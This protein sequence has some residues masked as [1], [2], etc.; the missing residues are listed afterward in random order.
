MVDTS[1][2]HAI[3][4]GD[5]QVDDD[6]NCRLEITP[7]DVLDLANDIQKNGLIQPVTVTPLKDHEKYKYRLICG[8]RRFKAHKGLEM[9]TIDCIVKENLDETAARLYNIKENLMR[10]QL[11]ILEEAKAIERLEHLGLT[12]M[13]AARE[14]QQSRGWVQVRFM[15][16]RLPREI[17]S[18]CAAGILTQEDIRELYTKDSDAQIN[19]VKTIKE[20]KLKGQSVA[21]AKAKQKRNP[22]AKRIRK[23]PEIFDMMEHLSKN[24]GFGIWTRAMAWIAGEITDRELFES[25]KE[26][27]DE[28]N[29]EY[30][31]PESGD[32]Y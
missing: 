23:R 1:K 32:Q 30:T 26:Y 10:K 20:A 21:R 16:L 24:I 12:E 15:L 18:E 25:M 9:P 29:I 13:D 4:L 5:I 28:N 31:I 2:V 19:Y 7:L 22:N 17:Q 8:F 6:F 3:P 27:C 14:L 11:N